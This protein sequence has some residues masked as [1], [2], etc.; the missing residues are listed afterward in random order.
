M[1]RCEMTD[2]EVAEMFKKAFG[3]W[4]DPSLPT[5]PPDMPKD[6]RYRLANEIFERDIK[7]HV[8]DRDDMDYVS[9]DVES[10]QWAVGNDQIAVRNELQDKQ[11]DA[12][13]VIS[14]RVG[15]RTVGRFGG[16][17]LVR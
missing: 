13:N 11:P 9:I 15:F 6:E 5:K 4:G 1:A 8:K 16:R 7:P 10:G 17:R 3:R 12:Y 14:R 2:D